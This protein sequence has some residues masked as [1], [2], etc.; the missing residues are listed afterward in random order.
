MF[1]HHVL[2][3][4]AVLASAAHAYFAYREMRGWGRDLV[5]SVA[6]RWLTDP[7]P[8]TDDQIAW[9]RDLAFNVG[10]YN[11]MLA[12]GLAWVAYDGAPKASLGIFFAV[13]L[14]VAAAVALHTGVMAAFYMQGV[15]GVM[16]LAA[17]IWAR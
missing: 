13:W 1:S 17:S 10:A 11:F 3:W 6:P 16:L 14:L 12:V 2:R 15:L 7:V 4:I 8:A 9:A 5:K